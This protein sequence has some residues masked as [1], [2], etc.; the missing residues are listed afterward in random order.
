MNI[1]VF[2]FRRFGKRGG[3]EGGCVSGIFAMRRWKRRVESFLEIKKGIIGTCD[4]FWNLFKSYHAKNYWLNLQKNFVIL[5]LLIV[6]IIIS[7][8]F[9][10]LKKFRS[11][12]MIWNLCHIF[13]KSSLLQI[14][15]YK[16]GPIYLKYTNQLKTYVTKCWT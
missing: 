13:F 2:D 15:W 12:Y 5:I 3:N 6:L 7:G 10:D 11:M 14:N 9:F 16:E 4:H 8:A 1:R